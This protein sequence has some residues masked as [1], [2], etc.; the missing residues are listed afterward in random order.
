MLMQTALR[1]CQEEIVSNVHGASINLLTVTSG[2]P[3]SL[4][5][6]LTGLRLK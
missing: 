6:N 3:A 1:H 4:A 5:A 2:W